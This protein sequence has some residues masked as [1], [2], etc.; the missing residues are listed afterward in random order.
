MFRVV[1]P[2]T[3]ALNAGSSNPSE[4][5]SVKLVMEVL[6]D[7]FDIHRLGPNATVPRQICD[8]SLYCVFRSDDELSLVCR[9]GLQLGAE[10]LEPGWAML[11]VRG[12]L[13]LSLKG[14]MARLSTAL[15]EASVAMFVLSSYD[16]DYVMVPV[17][18]LTP[19]CAALRTA[20]VDVIERG[21]LS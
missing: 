15:A 18:D 8:E 21:T 13:D 20:D 12:P 1:P 6:D 4:V 9:S 5:R 14:I 17:R 11:K 7:E 10:K 16:T 2:V 19:A 3:A